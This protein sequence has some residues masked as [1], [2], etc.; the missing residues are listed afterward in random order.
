MAQETI[1]AA[2]HGEVCSMCCCSARAFAGATALISAASLG[3]FLFADLLIN[4]SGVHVIRLQAVVKFD[5]GQTELSRNVKW[6][7]AGTGL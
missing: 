1:P 3:R 2:H 5:G 6:R 7:T 4:A